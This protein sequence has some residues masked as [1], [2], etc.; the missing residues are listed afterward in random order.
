MLEP[1]IKETGI[2]DSERYL[3]TL[4][5]KTF[6][7]LW[8]YPNV[9]TDEGY[10]KSKNGKELCD[11]LVVFENKII[12]F[13]DKNIVFNQEKDIKVAWKRW[14]KKSVLE[15]ASQLFGAES[16]IKNHSDR[17]FLDKKCENKFPIAIPKNGL[18]IFLIA[19]TKNSSEPAKKYY[20]NFAKGS[21]GTLVQNYNMSLEQCLDNPFNIS[22]SFPSKTFIHILD[23]LS[24]DLLISKLDTIH[25]FTTYL[26]EKERAIRTNHL[27]VIHGEEDLLGYFYSNIEQDLAGR[28]ELPNQGSSCE[29]IIQEGFWDSFIKTNEYKIIESYRKGSVHWDEMISNFSEHILGASVYHGKE[30]SF[31]SHEIALKYM[32]SENRLSRCHLCKSF[33]IKFSSVPHNARSALV[34]ESPQHEGRIYTFLFFPRS[35][36][37]SDSDYREC[38]LG[39]ALAYSIVVK[40]Q[41]PKAKDVIVIATET[42]QNKTRS[43]DIIAKH[44]DEQLST[45]EKKEARNIMKEFQILTNTSPKKNPVN[46]ET[47]Y[48]NHSKE[49]GRNDK[50]K[51]GSGK[52]FK[53]CC[54]QTMSDY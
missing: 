23:E 30:N 35:D 53:K 36:G 22:D 8:C 1:I 28:I 10:S 20:D 14:F 29:Y 40:Y 39:A 31:E 44:Y 37:M 41:N 18:E 13:S 43:E 5:E 34:M 49:I 4:S 52:K 26:I 47:P 38:R 15:S 11:L 54:M 46:Y 50:C 42:R 6:L 32:A 9:Y 45:D 24:L 2:N 27:R 16:W 17:I 48:I 21:T 3:A 7:S 33:L 19:V 12:I 51:C 25:D